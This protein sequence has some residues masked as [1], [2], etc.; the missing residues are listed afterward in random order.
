MDQTTEGAK[1]A[2]GEVHPLVAARAAIESAFALTK[3][4]EMGFSLQCALQVHSLL[5]HA[6]EHLDQ[7]A[8][9][10]RAK[11]ESVRDALL[12]DHEMQVR[13]GRFVTSRMKRR[14]AS[15][16]PAEQGAFEAASKL[17]DGAARE[18]AGWLVD[19]VLGITN[20]VLA[21]EKVDT[22]C[23]PFGCTKCNAVVFVPRTAG[24]TGGVCT[25]QSRGC[26]G[27]I[28]KLDGPLALAVRGLMVKRRI[29]EQPWLTLVIGGSVR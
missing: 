6:I 3:D 14:A 24:I 11:R 12:A 22:G 19:V 29:V 7:A 15:I 20:D 1:P 26:E 8:S 13:V 10:A 16:Q 9:P 21:P 18:L 2:A 27:E 25:Q 5:G 23:D 4:P 17:E 28:T